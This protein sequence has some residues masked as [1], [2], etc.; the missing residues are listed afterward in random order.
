MFKKWIWLAVMA[1]LCFNVKTPV[2]SQEAAHV[3]FANFV[4]NGPQVNIFVDGNLFTDG[5]K[6]PYALNATELSRRYV[7]LSPYRPHMFAVVP[8]GKTVDAALFEPLPFTLNTGHNYALAIMGNVESK[9]MHFKLIDETAALAPYDLKV[10]AVSV[11]FDNL[12]GLP[13]VDLYWGGKLVLPNIAYGDYAV[14]QD[15][16]EGKGSKMTPH[17]DVNT[18]LFEFPDAIHGPAQTI[19]FFG[20]AGKYPGTLW[21]DYTTPYVGNYLGTPVKRD[22]GSISVGEVVKVSMTDVGVRYD[23]K[24]VLDKDMSLDIGLSGSPDSTD[25]YL[26]VFDSA[27][28]L[29]AEND[30]IA[31][32][33]MN[34]DAAVKGLKLTK[35]TYTVEAASAFDTFLGDYTLSVQA[36]Q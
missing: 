15:P 35:G 32:G 28:K 19:A 21:E 13:A 2:A 27:G 29:I 26:R 8:A 18:T 22:S 17:G 36:S 3:R 20:I 31:R 9:D 10:S 16:I 1:F 4:F 25:A 5:A 11:V 7:D 12:Y 6:L 14:V 34:R 23:Y 33:A 30:D 24:L